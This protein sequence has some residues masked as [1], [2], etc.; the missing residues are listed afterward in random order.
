MSTSASGQREGPSGGAGTSSGRSAECHGDG[1]SVRQPG[2]TPEELAVV[3]AG[4]RQLAGRLDRIRGRLGELEQA[5]Q[6]WSGST[7][8]STRD[9][10]S[11]KRSRSS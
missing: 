11:P 8:R 5:A 4:L 1:A 2:L 9:S 10:R 7:R 3:T 6:S